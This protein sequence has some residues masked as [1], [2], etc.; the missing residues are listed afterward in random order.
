MTM[1]GTTRTKPAAGV[2]SMSSNWRAPATAAQGQRPA[3]HDNDSDSAT[4]S[5]RRQQTETGAGQRRL[6]DGALASQPAEIG[7][8]A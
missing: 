1:G 2:G 8:K 7:A 4:E 3:R 6:A 5:K